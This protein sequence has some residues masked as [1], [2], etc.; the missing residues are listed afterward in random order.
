LAAAVAM[1]TARTAA[2]DGNDARLQAVPAWTRT[3][4]AVEGRTTGECCWP[5]LMEVRCRLLE[6]WSGTSPGGQRIG[7]PRPGQ[8]DVVAG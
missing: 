7:C 8:S 3:S 4:M 2:L 6:R 1:Q 5:V